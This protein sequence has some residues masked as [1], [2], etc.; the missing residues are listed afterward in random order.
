MKTKIKILTLA[1]IALPMLISAQTSSIERLY[2][3]YAGEDGF[4]SINIS[5][6]MFTFFIS[7]DGIE[8]EE[9]KDVQNVLGNLNGLKILT[10]DAYGSK[11]ENF[12]DEIK[13]VF[14]DKEFTELMNIKEQGNEVKFMVRKDGE[15]IIELLM[16]ASENRQISIISFFGLIDLNAIS[17]LSNSVQF[18]GMD[19]LEKLRN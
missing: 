6:E 3:K 7:L 17:K 8:D 11:R 5:K 19:K 18:H 16:V 13:A 2:D 9:V 15:D 10:Y 12:L 1:L 14:K 4:T